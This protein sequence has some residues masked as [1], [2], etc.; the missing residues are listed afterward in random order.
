MGLPAIC[1]ILVPFLLFKVYECC[2]QKR[3]SSSEQVDNDLAWIIFIYTLIHSFSPHKEFR[4]LLPI[5]P[6]VCVLAGRN[7]QTIC[8]KIPKMKWYLVLSLIIFN[9]PHLY[10]L[11]KIHQ[12][13]PIGINR[14][15]LKIVSLMDSN[16]HNL[17]IHYLMGCHSTPLYSHLHTD[18]VKFQA[19]TLDCSPTCRD[20][21]NNL[22]CES[23]QF[24][25]DPLSFIQQTY[26]HLTACDNSVVQE[27]TVT[28]NSPESIKPIPDFVA[29]FQ[30]DAFK[31]YEILSDMKFEQVAKVRHAIK[32]MN[33][34]SDSSQNTETD[35]LLIDINQMISIR[36]EFESILLFQRKHIIL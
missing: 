31:I 7:L 18:N 6:L 36:I 4:F 20:P 28:N 12:H 5:L 30:T 27:C 24:T 21:N 33:C 25:L 2:R 26:Y 14:E 34:S 16:E 9:Y 10:F 1:G 13:G 3:K 15:I 19:W 32:K 8:Q 29:I 23:E 35:D 11:S 17:T 22:V